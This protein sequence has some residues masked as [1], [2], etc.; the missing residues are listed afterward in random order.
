[1]EFPGVVLGLVRV[2]GD[3]ADDD[4]A[5]EVAVSALLVEVTG[6]ALCFGLQS[7]GLLVVA[8]QEL[9]FLGVAELHDARS[10]ADRAALQGEAGPGERRRIRMRG[11]R[12]RLTAGGEEVIERGD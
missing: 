12:A 3:A 8:L 11:Q 2:V 4:I 5:G 9:A 6:D 10:G 1:G 7:E